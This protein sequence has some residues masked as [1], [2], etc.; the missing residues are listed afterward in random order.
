MLSCQ[1][2][3]CFSFKRLGVVFSAQVPV[4]L[5]DWYDLRHPWENEVALGCEEF[6]R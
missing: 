2:L 4:G 6:P 3:N 5:L 1:S